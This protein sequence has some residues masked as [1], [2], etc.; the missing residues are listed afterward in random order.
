MAENGATPAEFSALLHRLCE[1][2]GWEAGLL[3][4]PSADGATLECRA[5]HGRAEPA[6][7]S[8][9]LP[10]GSGLP[11][12]AWMTGRALWIPDLAEEFVT[13]RE[14]AARAAGLCCALAVPAGGRAVL[15][16]YAAAPRDRNEALISLIR[17][18]A[19]ATL[20]DPQRRIEETSL[21]NAN[22]RLHFL[23]RS[24]TDAIWTSDLRTRTGWWN[25]AAY[26]LIG[27]APGAIEPS[28]EAWSARVHPDDRGELMAALQSHFESG[29]ASWTEEYRVL[30]AD[31]GVRF[32]LGRTY[33]RRDE[34][35]HPV[36]ITGV[37]IDLTER[38]LAEL[39]RRDSDLRLKQA[40]RMTHDGLWD[41]NFAPDRT[42]WSDA[43][44]QLLGYTPGEVTPTEEA[45]AAR[46]H[47]GDRERVLGGY[48]AALA[49]RDHSWTE[50]YRVLL[51]SGV[52]RIL[53]DCGYL[54]C[55]AA[56]RPQRMSGSARD[57]TELRRAENTLRDS[58]RTLAALLGNLPGLV[59]RVGPPPLYAVE[60]V[61]QGSLELTGYTPDE[62]RGG[63][64]PALHILDLVHPDDR[65]AIEQELQD[66]L[67]ARRPYRLT[68]R[69]RTRDGTEKW[70]LNQG[71]G[72]YDAQ[73]N[74]VAL[75]GIVFD[76]SDRKRAEEA[77]R[78]GDARLRQV[79]DSPLI[80]IIFWNEAGGISDANDFFLK[81]VGY[82]REDLEA[83][84]IRW[85]DLTPPE[86]AE[87]DRKAIEEVR[88]T[89]RATPY[90]KEYFRKDGSR[91]PILI[92]GTSFG[93]SS[94]RG[95]AVVLDVSERRHV[96][97][98][99]IQ[100]QKMES[101]GRLAGGIA[102]DFNNLLTSILGHGDLALQRLADPHPVRAHLEEI[103]SAGQRAAALTH[104]LLAF[105][106][107]QI[108]QPRIIS[109]SS[110]VQGLESLLRRTIGE[111]IQLLCVLDPALPSVR[112]D[113]RQ[114]EQAVMNLVVNAR[115]AM[116]GGGQ[117]TL[118]TFSCLVDPGSAHAPPGL[119][120]GPHAALSVTDTGTGM[121]ADV[122]RHLF[123]PFFTTKEV[124]KGTGLGLSTSYGIVR[125]SGGSITLSSEPGRGSVFTL[126]LP[127]VPGAALPEPAP[128]EPPA[129]PGAETILLAEDE[130]MV[131]KLA[132]EILRRQ[133]YT[134]L[135]TSHGEEAL[136]LL[137]KEGDRVHLLLTDVVMPRM[138][139]PELARRARLERPGLPVL[140]MSGYPGVEAPAEIPGSLLEKPFTAARLIDKIRAVLDAAR[141]P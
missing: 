42:W 78:A 57:L 64:R 89:G 9:P 119:L 126:Y 140:F 25:E 66:A 54:E 138:G 8:A 35:G 72:A 56:G 136:E 2:T 91:V 123:E 61:S 52:C 83:G 135:E 26:R 81:M 132:S 75:E 21:R 77:V 22:E 43:F 105:S 12:R 27:Y 55:D 85:K 33:L 102:H 45:W 112:A 125:Q 106:R 131:R 30:Q 127:A 63:L 37:V 15:E 111:D 32:V 97:A 65:V 70:V 40:A 4:L 23:A 121:G 7:G 79:F 5:R 100:A 1:A 68:F 86:Y 17:D 24:L 113:P 141:R 67:P 6:L 98:K 87:L 53:F 47:P 90:E 109:L 120:A 74:L 16:F 84:R 80:G 76:I 39:A 13:R 96:E 20:Q 88:L 101:V 34:A 118:R 137:R 60:Y 95:L 117:L 19:E 115:D 99:F 103:R 44:Q 124:G 128:A 133:G 11:G 71:S 14:D 139:G 28:F 31:G 62:L 108:L 49:R 41:R 29:A 51:P 134:V 94:G 18:L 59:Y 104:Q 129:M 36:F 73:R 92:G 10:P 110:V 38:R 116:P 58:Q 50:E 122:I 130:E 3:W 93:P 107:K 46:I 48:R 114:I 69:L 82:S